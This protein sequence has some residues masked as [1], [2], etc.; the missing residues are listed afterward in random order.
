MQI[1]RQPST[2]ARMSLVYITVGALAVIWTGVWYFYL[3][4][5]PPVTSTPYYWCAG[6][7]VTGFALMIIGL[8]VGQ[9]GRSARKAEH[10]A[11]VVATPPGVVAPS[12]T[13]VPAASSAQPAVAVP[14]EPVRGNGRAEPVT[15]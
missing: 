9:I 6:F 2:A 11:H 4:N 15:K 1:F 14:L 13:A 10:P 8:G 12:T 3:S 7:L 5:H